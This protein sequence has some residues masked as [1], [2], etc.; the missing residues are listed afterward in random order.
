[1]SFRFQWYVNS[2]LTILYRSLPYHGQ[3]MKVYLLKLDKP[4]HQAKHFLQVAHT[5]LQ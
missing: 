3:L 4:E 2:H 5:N 1:M